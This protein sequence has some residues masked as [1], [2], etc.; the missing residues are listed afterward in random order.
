VSG[1]CQKPGDMDDEAFIKYLSTSTG[2]YGSS[3]QSELPN[4]AREASL[5]LHIVAVTAH[6]P[7]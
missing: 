4:H 6:R 1:N 2:N 5:I 3:S 7:S